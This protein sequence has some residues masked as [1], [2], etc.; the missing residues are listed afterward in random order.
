MQA[1]SSGRAALC[2]IDEYSW[3]VNCSHTSTRILHVMRMH[4]LTPAAAAAAVL[5]HAAA[6][7]A[8]DARHG[9]IIRPLTSCPLPSLQSV[10]SRFLFRP[11]PHIVQVHNSISST[12]TNPF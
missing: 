8:G 3:Q 11:Q 10:A 9:C 1:E 12:T 4:I 5:R 7:V 2:E 6:V